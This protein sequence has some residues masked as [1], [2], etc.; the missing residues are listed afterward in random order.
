MANV[1][2][3]P[4]SPPGPTSAAAVPDRRLRKLVTP[5]GVDLRLEIADAGARGGAFLLDMMIIVGSLIVV[6]FAAALTY[7]SGAQNSGVVQIVWLLAFFFL[8]NGYFIAFELSPRAATP[9]KRALGLRVAS[10][11]GG[12]LTAQ[13]VFARNAMRELEVFLP[14]SFLFSGA[15]DIDAVIVLAGTIWSAIFVLFPVFNRDRLRAGDLIAGTWVIKN[16]RREL[17]VDLAAA[18]HRPAAGF[19][20]ND[21]QL[22]AY[23]VHELQVLEDVLRR[24]NPET[25]TAVAKRIRTK[26]QWVASASETDRDFLAAYYP[27]LRRRLEAKLLMGVRRR[28]KHDKR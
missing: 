1:T 12:R 18:D 16:P 22:D 6:S 25:L 27:A 9:G 28:D 15:T 8:R 2:S 10:R 13:A 24:A 21:E 17:S 7:A 4:G 3:P 20:F 5:E 14:I 19:E 23:G 11:D 26:I